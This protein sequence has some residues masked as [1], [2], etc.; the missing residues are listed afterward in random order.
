MTL[1]NCKILLKH[2]QDLVDGTIPRPVGHKDWA[3]VIANAKVR[4]ALME[5]NIERKTKRYIE[6]GW[7]PKLLQG[8][9][10]VDKK[11]KNKSVTSSEVSDGKR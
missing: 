9:G 4:A 10:A 7:L 6:L 3:D 2:Y 11:K 8:R 5:I 1:A